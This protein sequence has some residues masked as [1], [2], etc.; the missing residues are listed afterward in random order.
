MALKVANPLE[1]KD[2]SCLISEGGHQKELKSLI[3]TNQNL[4][5]RHSNF[6]LCHFAC[7]PRQTLIV[8]RRWCINCLY[9]SSWN[10]PWSLTLL[11][12]FLQRLTSSTISSM[13]IQDSTGFL[14]LDSWNSFS[15]WCLFTCAFDTNR[16][17]VEV[18]FSL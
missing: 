1:S 6:T 7:C 13:F 14:K 9:P 15:Y 8:H 16:K 5:I 4:L 2:F 18:H 10:W 12:F 3:W 11:D 17:N